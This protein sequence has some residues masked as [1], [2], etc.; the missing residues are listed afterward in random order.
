MHEALLAELCYRSAS[1]QFARVVMM[2]NLEVTAVKKRSCRS[3]SGTV[4]SKSM[5][6]LLSFWTIW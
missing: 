1:V 3:Q 5:D 4:A 2:D 6:R